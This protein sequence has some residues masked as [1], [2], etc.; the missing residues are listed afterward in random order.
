MHAGALYLSQERASQPGAT[1]G[2]PL[3]SAALL[4]DEQEPEEESSEEEWVPERIA[5]AD[6]R[7][8]EE[9]EIAQLLS[10][11]G[12]HTRKPAQAIQQ[13]MSES[14]SNME[15]WS[16]DDE[17]GEDWSDGEHNTSKD[18]RP[19]MPS[20]AELEARRYAPDPDK[21]VLQQMLGQV[22]WRRSVLEGGPDL[23]DLLMDF[24][25]VCSATTPLPTAACTNGFQRHS[26]AHEPLPEDAVGCVCGACGHGSRGECPHA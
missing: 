4:R 9:E 16:E 2:A 22:A 20:Q 18:I 25:E 17:S 26:M 12:G 11:A 21:S 1:P 7:P 13:E 5:A 14:S 6:C 3:S 23:G 15:G 24:L 8:I 19:S 10:A